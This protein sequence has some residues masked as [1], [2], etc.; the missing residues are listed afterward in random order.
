MVCG[1]SLFLYWHGLN[2]YERDAQVR[3]FYE[4]PAA[5]LDL[6]REYNVRYI[7]LGAS[8]RYELGADEAALDALFETVYDRLG[9]K[10]YKVVL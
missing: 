8:E 3:A 7:V 6:L 1:P 5:N 10:V 4:D 2:Y 9:T